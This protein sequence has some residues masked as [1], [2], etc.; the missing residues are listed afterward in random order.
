MFSWFRPRCPIDLRN[1]VWVEYR[2]QHLIDRI[3]E[4]ELRRYPILI[5]TANDL[6][7]I[8]PA[9]KGHLEDLLWRLCEQLRI[10]RH[11]I[12]LQVVDS[13]SPSATEEDAPGTSTQETRTIRLYRDLLDKP[14][15]LVSTLIHELLHDRLLREGILRGDESDLEHL[16]DL[17]AC[18]FGCGIPLAN[19]TLAFES[20]TT[21][22]YSKW[23]MWRTGYLTALD[24]G[25]ALAVL[26]WRNGEE[27]IPEWT[28]WLSLDAKETF[29]RGL[30]Y[31]RSTGDCWLSPLG[32][33][34]SLHSSRRNR[35]KKS[36][37]DTERLGSLWDIV[38]SG[39]RVAPEDLLPLLRHREASIRLA[40]CEALYRT[41]ARPEF[42]DDL[43][44]TTSDEH[45]A[46]RGAA[47]ATFL[48]CFPADSN[49]T[50]IVTQGLSDSNI[51]AVRSTLFALWESHVW[52][53]E[54]QD[55]VLGAFTRSVGRVSGEGVVDYLY[56][57]SLHI[58]SLETFLRRHFSGP[59]NR[60][61]LSTILSCLRMMQESEPD[62]SPKPGS[63]SSPA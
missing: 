55:A 60:S 51:E 12:D 11:G 47:I 35:L 43:Y 31:L 46:V 10:S 32:E 24:L 49:V 23:Q 20:E 45:G 16:T 6:P 27:E 33:S 61:E 38:A 15:L 3:G 30:K 7:E 19:S 37:T 18:L 22:T 26:H 17:S 36:Q 34:R 50:R 39:I 62:E 53:P 13:S 41:P 54:I 1:K 59:E 8:A 57:L 48:K 42:R 28:R 44:G 58:P 63:D 56:V 40:A 25:Y 9:Q 21:G 29:I 52:N 14:A 2:L 4:T 5:P